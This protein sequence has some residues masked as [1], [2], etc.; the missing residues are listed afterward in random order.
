MLSWLSGRTRIL[1]SLSVALAAI[2]L[3]HHL[4]ISAISITD[5]FKTNNS[6][7]IIV[8]KLAD[9]ADTASAKMSSTGADLAMPATTSKADSP[10]KMPVYFFSHGGPTVQYDTKH[11]AYPVLQ[12]IGK[13]ITH[14]LKPKAVI[15]FSAHWMG[16]EDVIH[17]NSKEQT[18]LIYDFY[19]FPAHFYKA[20]YPNKGSPELA[21]KIIDTLAEAGIKSLPVK[22]GLDH[23]VWSGF[24][25]AFNPETNPLNVPLVQVSLFKSEDPRSHYALG[26]A[27]SHLRQEGVVMIGAGMSVH[28]LG[29]LHL[30]SN[31]NSKPLP[32][33]VSF[34]K[35]I[36]AAVEVDPSERE[37]KM[38]EL[39]RRPDARQAHPFMDHLMPLYIAA[40]AAYE[41]RGRQTWTMQEGSMAWAQYRFGAVP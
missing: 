15:V 31:G 7:A 14:K 19:G 38:A 36:K 12:K 22:R 16:D 20:K 11:P 5:I 28:N 34:D 35:A 8:D 24:S 27:L 17:V 37:G 6:S 18:D 40:G 23:G 1:V 32:Y 33:A 10:S 25:V 41:D 13:E 9:V 3:A 21:N 4:D 30:M 2:Y 39:C 26:R 29:D